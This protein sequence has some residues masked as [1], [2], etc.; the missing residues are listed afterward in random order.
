MQLILINHESRL[1]IHMHIVL[2]KFEK[3]NYKERKANHAC[4]PNYQEHKQ[5]LVSLAQLTGIN[6]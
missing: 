2:L 3:K 4:V 1:S 5:G 6:A